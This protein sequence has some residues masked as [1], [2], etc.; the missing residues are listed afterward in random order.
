MRPFDRIKF[1][2]LGQDD[3]GGIK[4]GDLGQN[5][6]KTERLLFLN[7]NHC[8]RYLIYRGMIDKFVSKSSEVAHLPPGVAG[9]TDLTLAHMLN[10]DAELK[11]FFQKSVGFVSVNS[12]LADA[13]RAMGKIDKCRDVFV[14][15]SGDRKEPI[16]GWITDSAIRENLRV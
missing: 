3:G 13:K 7:E 16:L 1:M 6:L 2:P 10:S 12:S 9:V 11:A 14:T 5:F 4:L 15:Q 8:F